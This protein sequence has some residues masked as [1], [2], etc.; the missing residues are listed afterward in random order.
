MSSFEEEQALISAGYGNMHSDDIDK[1]A[2]TSL[3]NGFVVTLISSE[4]DELLIDS[5]IIQSRY[6]HDFLKDN[7]GTPVAWNCDYLSMN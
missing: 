3:Y 1:E 2:V 6:L 5:I 7:Y 4:T